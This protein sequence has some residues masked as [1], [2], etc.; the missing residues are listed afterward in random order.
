MCCDKEMPIWLTRIRNKLFNLE[1]SILNEENIDQ[2]D[3]P[4]SEKN[5]VDDISVPIVNIPKETVLEDV[6]QDIAKLFKDI[7]APKVPPRP[8]ISNLPTTRTGRKTKVPQ[9]LHGYV[10]K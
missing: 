9:H 4:E 5:Q 6:L 3:T 8:V 7:R 1:T 2:I 10:A